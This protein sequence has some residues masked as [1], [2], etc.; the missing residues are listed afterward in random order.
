[1]FLFLSH[2]LSIS[3]KEQLKET[4]TSSIIFT[5]PPIRDL[6]VL[7]K[8]SAYIKTEIP[9]TFITLLSKK[10]CVTEIEIQN[11]EY[12]SDFPETIIVSAYKNGWKQIC[13]MHCKRT[14]DPQKF[15]LRSKFR[16]KF[17]KFDVLSKIGGHGFICI[18]RVNVCGEKEDKNEIVGFQNQDEI[19]Y[20]M[21]SVQRLRRV[22]VMGFFV[23]VLMLVFGVVVG[24]LNFFEVF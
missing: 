12:F 8:T 22:V 18:S 4:I 2:L 10:V 13:K 1:M 9:F 23:A 14:R 3:L 21:D 7:N 19:F 11:A 20:L 15:A 24:F 16:T 17:L 5:Y 6:S